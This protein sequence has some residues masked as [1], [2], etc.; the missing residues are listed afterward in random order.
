MFG[1][2]NI[3]R[4]LTKNWF[5][6]LP[7]IRL[8]IYINAVT[9]L[10]RLI[11]ISNYVFSIIKLWPSFLI[12]MMFNDHHRGFFVWYEIITCKYIKCSWWR[13]WVA[14]S[15]RFYLSLKHR[16]VHKT[17]WY[18]SREHKILCSSTTKLQTR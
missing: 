4:K 6:W 12:P 13:G 16:T 14:I 5:W 10:P 3:R 9:L 1:L 18:I 15:L 8:F 11:R 17:I 2:G 7:K